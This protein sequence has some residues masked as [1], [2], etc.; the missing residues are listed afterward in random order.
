MTGARTGG[1]QFEPND[2]CRNGG[3]EDISAVSGGFLSINNQTNPTQNPTV[4]FAYLINIC[5]GF[6][7]LVTDS[8][9]PSETTAIARLSTSRNLIGF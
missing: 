5:N 6:S 9:M 7:D 3:L 2:I 4:T 1:R 8:C